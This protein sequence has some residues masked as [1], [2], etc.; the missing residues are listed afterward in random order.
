MPD[1]FVAFADSPSAPSR[2]PFTLTPNDSAALASIPK[3]IYVGTGG[4]IVLRGIDGVAD[5]TF[6]NVPSGATLDVRALF[7]RATGTTA[8]NLVAFA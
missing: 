1:Q 7:V 6:V 4:S 2:A 3:A 8:S 5:V